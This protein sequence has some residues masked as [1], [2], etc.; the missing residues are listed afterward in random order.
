MGEIIQK[1]VVATCSGVCAPW[2]RI[3]ILLLSS[4]HSAGECDHGSVIS[5]CFHDL[6]RDT[7]TSHAMWCNGH[8]VIS[9]C[10]HDL[11][12]DTDTCHAM[13]WNGH[14]VNV[15][16]PVVSLWV[17]RPDCSVS[18]RRNV[19]FLLSARPV[20]S[21]IKVV[22]G[23]FLWFSHPET[24]LMMVDCDSVLSP[25]REEQIVVRVQP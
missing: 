4:L 2:Y 10:C 15:T 11:S 13:W 9:G 1:V 16:W 12:R 8:M 21:N 25:S 20:I 23:V 24:M 17:L 7:D 14:V 18:S 3:Y 5:A 6:S 19:A 22:A